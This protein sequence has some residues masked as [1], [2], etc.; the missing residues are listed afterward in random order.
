MR[1]VTKDDF[2]FSTGAE[3]RKTT[4]LVKKHVRVVT[5]IEKIISHHST[6]VETENTAQIG[7]YIIKSSDEGDGYIILAHRFFEIYEEDPTN[8]LFYRAKV[9]RTGLTVLEDMKFIAPWGQE[10][11]ISAGGVIIEAGPYIYGVDIFDFIDGYGR[12]DDSPEKATFAILNEPLEN[13]LQK[14]K[15]LGLKNHIS[16]IELRLKHENIFKNRYL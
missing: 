7:D 16:D 1:I 3:Y 2:D 6:G 11:N 12:V 5:E 14:A 9:T 15:Q 8:D 4:P 10:Q 13:Q